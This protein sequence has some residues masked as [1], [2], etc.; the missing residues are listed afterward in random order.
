MTLPD[1]FIEHGDYKDQLAEA[2]LTA[3]QIAGT[4]LQV[5]GWG[6]EARP[7]FTCL[8]GFLAMTSWSSRSQP[9]F[10]FLAN[11][12]VDMQVM[13]RAKDAAKFSLGTLAR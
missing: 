11:L 4:V 9:A 3:G 8:S 13:G 10:N 5:H 6:R 2:G 1:R 12:L 7:P